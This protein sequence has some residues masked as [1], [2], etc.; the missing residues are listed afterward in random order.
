MCTEQGIA[1]AQAEAAVTQAQADLDALPEQQRQALAKL[2]A[3]HKAARILAAARVRSAHGQADAAAQLQEREAA[4]IAATA[5]ASTDAYH[6]TATALAGAHHAA[7]SATAQAQPTPAPN[8]II[9][10]A[11]GR[12]VH[13]SAEEK[14]GR[15]T[16]TLEVMP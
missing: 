12:V 10:H 16:V 4:Q 1:R 9:S 15:L 11:A 3:D 7:V 13:V 14:D 2:D 6:A 5:V 8:T